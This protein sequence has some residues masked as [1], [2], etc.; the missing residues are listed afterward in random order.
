MARPMDADSGLTRQVL[1][2]NNKALCIVERL[3]DLRRR[4]DL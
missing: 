2:M 4:V 3:I 1:E